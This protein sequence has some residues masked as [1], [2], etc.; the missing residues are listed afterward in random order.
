MPDGLA[1]DPVWMILERPRPNLN[2]RRF[3]ALGRLRLEDRRLEFGPSAAKLRLGPSPKASLSTDQVVRVRLERHGWGLVPR[4]VAID[5]RADDGT[6]GVAHFNNAEWNGWRPLLTG[7]NRR[8]AEA[9]KKHLGL[10]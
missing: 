9:I 4:F 10:E 6:T 2:P 3:F 1:F 7:V 8:T 5:H